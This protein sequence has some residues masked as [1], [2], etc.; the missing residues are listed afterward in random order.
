VDGSVH[1]SRSSADRR[2]DAKLQGL[3]YRIVRVDA[4]L[5]ARAPAEALA[6]IR[7]ALP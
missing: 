3:G 7:G 4:A 5:V 2:R 1:P 6:V